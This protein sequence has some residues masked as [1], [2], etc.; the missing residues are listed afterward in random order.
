MKLRDT[1]CNLEGKL[2]HIQKYGQTKIAKI[3]SN[4]SQ[5]FY[6]FSSIEH[7]SHYSYQVI[8]TGNLLQTLLSV[9]DHNIN[10]ILTFC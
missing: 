8:T 9:W 3:S 2:H 5:E 1:G 4:N 7:I 6:S 10:H